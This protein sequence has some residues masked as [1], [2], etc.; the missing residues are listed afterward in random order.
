MRQKEKKGGKRNARRKLKLSIN[1]THIDVQPNRQWLAFKVHP[2]A[3]RHRR[4]AT[5]LI[6][7]CIGELSAAKLF[8]H[9]IKVVTENEVIVI[10]FRRIS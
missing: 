8:V 10:T 7:V 2:E 4:S 3:Q 1:G 5:I 6:S 9:V